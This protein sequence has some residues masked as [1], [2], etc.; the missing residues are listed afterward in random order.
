MLI[1]GDFNNGG[2]A[3]VGF[4]DTAA[5]ISS[6]TVNALN[7]I[8]GVDDV[9]YSFGTATPEPGTLMLFGSGILGLAGVIR[10]KINL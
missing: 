5:N 4:T 9:R 6:V 7:D 2:T 10:R 3:F 8:I 1:P